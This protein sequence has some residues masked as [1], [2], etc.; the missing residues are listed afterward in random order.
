MQA[1]GRHARHCG[2][3]TARRGNHPSAPQPGLTRPVTR[4]ELGALFDQIDA[5]GSGWLNIK[6][7]TEALRTWQAR[8]QE[9]AA[10]RQAKETEHTML[11]R[12]AARLMQAALRAIKRFR[13]DRRR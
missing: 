8:S 3:R 2:L 13:F 4:K 5:D 12:R 6:E 1:T 7:L 10:T 11:R 9:E